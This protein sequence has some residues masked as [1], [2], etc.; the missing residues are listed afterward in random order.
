MQCIAAVK[1]VLKA[2]K[3]IDPDFDPLSF[4]KHEEILGT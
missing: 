3:M 4:P 2:R 1:S